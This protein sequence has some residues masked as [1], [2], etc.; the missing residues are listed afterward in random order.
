MAAVGAASAAVVLGGAPQTAHAARGAGTGTAATIIRNGRV[1]RGVNGPTADA[2]AIG[3]DGLILAVGR[4]RDLASLGTT[5]TEVIDARGGTVMAGLQDGHVHPM[6]AGLRSLNPSMEDAE[7]TAAGVQEQVAGFLAD[8]N[9]G[10]Q[11]PDNWLTVE[12]WNPAA[13]PT[14]TTAHKDILDAILVG[15]NPNNRPLALNGSDGHNLWVNSRAL[16]IAGIDRD[17][18]DPDGGVIVKDA[19]GKPTGVLKDAAQALVT[20]FIPA[21][22]PEQM[23]GSFQGAFAQMA[24]GGITSAL[25]AWVDDWQLD[26]YAELAS[27]GHLLQ[28]VTPALRLTDEMVAD[29][30]ASLEWAQ[31]LAEAYA[32]VPG[33]TFGTIKV[34]MDGVIEYPA[35]TAA[36]IE[37]YLDIDGNPTDNYGELYIDKKTMGE[38]VTVFDKAGWQVHAHAIGDAGVRA[39]LDGYEIARRANGPTGNRHTIAHLQLVHPTDYARFARLDV[40]PDMQLQWAIRNVWTDEALK[41]FIGSER[42][43][44]LYPAKSLLKA[45]AALA[46]GSDWPVDPLMPWNQ[47]QTAIDRVGADSYGPPPLGAHE[48]LTREQSLMIHT[49]GTAY[50]LHQEKETGTL[51]PGKL[52]DV[53]ILD[54]DITTGP[55]S[56]INEASPVLTLLGGKPTFDSTTT[57]G[58]AT[59]TAMAAGAA[60]AKVRPSR[61]SHDKIGGRPGCPC[62]SEGKHAR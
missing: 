32:E 19:D 8:P 18:E 47:V 55:V 51:E 61:V 38:L 10:V 2:V 13:T 17:T 34:F 24:A 3:G 56:E 26:S 49:R 41:P 50:Q 11:G 31:G 58:R 23:Y 43:K 15:G 35:Q 62:G 5:Q 20:E 36:L 21:P 22:T 40:V 52:A 6:Y 29:P 28:R 42:H 30:K 45:G 57:A 48:K 54:R 44:R 14:D 1:F 4:Y 53:V 59:A 16:E 25:D 27:N 60:A 37:P 39:A 12:G 46:G 33:L 7:L 9:Y